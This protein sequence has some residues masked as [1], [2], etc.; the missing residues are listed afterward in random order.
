MKE[1]DI[2]FRNEYPD[3]IKEGDLEKIEKEQ[4]K[5]LKRKVYEIELEE[6]LINTYGKI[7]T[8]TELQEEFIVKSFTSPFIS[9]TRKSDN[10][11]GIL[12]FS[13]MP[14]FYFNFIKD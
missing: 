3:L 14:R 1:L 10:T 7:Y 12:Q 4:Q 2:E 13:H 11:N 8:T 5:F 6:E 9:V